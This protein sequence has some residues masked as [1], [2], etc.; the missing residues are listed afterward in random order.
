MGYLKEHPK[1]QHYVVIDD[2][3]MRQYFKDRM[4]YTWDPGYL[5][6]TH[7]TEAESVLM[8]N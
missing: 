7:E 2:E 3:D 8:K 1:L 4:V 6:G 5:N